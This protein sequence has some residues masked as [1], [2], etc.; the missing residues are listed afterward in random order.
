MRI[1]KPFAEDAGVADGAVVELQLVKGQIV[2]TP[3][4]DERVQLGALLK[5]VTKRNRHGEQSTGKP[6]GREPW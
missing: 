4:V 2:A 1:P 3:V 5:R 6:L